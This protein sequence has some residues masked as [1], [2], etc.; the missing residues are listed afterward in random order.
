MD[1][2][3]LAIAIDV[4]PNQADGRH[5]VATV[6]SEQFVGCE[7]KSGH[8]SRQPLSVCISP[9]EIEVAFSSDGNIEWN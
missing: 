3:R 8:E 4:G 9:L 1:R 7:P 6:G 5:V 2:D